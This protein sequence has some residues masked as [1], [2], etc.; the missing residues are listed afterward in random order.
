[1]TSATAVSS[2]H[3]TR[4]IKNP[5]QPK[6]FRKLKAKKR[7]NTPS[8]AS[9]LARPDLQRSQRP[10]RRTSAAVPFLLPFLF[11]RTADALHALA[12]VHDVADLKEQV[13]PWRRR[14]VLGNK[15]V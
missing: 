3:K 8:I 14:D 4:D 1:M 12:N 7:L 11:L 9:V 15:D 2:L 13:W 10:P 5:L 6:V